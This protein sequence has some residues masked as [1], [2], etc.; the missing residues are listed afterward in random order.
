MYN[1]GVQRYKVGITTDEFFRKVRA[2]SN[3][4]ME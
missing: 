2:E 1:W 4:G 3:Y